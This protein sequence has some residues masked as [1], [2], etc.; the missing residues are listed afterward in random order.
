MMIKLFILGVLILFGNPAWGDVTAWVNKN[1]VVV[2]DM[3]QLHVEAKN[4][5]DAE[6]PDLSEITGFQILNRSVQN[7]TSIVGTSITRTLSW[8]Y[9]MIAPSSG[10]YLIPALKVGNEQSTPI[11]LKVTAYS[12]NQ[13]QKYVSLDME[14]FPKKVY[15]QQQI[16]VRLRISRTGVQLENETITPFELKGALVEELSQ[17]SHQTVKNG[18]KHKITEILY[19]V[20][21]E[22]SGTLVIPQV[23]YQGEIIQRGSSQNNFGNIFQKRGQRI[24]ST[25]TTQSVEVKALP[26]GFKNWW[27]PTD[28]LVIEEKWQPDP[29]VFRVGEPVTR[30]VAIFVNGVSGN[31]IPELKFDYPVTLKGYADQP[32]I[33][34]EK[35]EKGLKGMRLEKWALIPSQ[36]GKIELPGVSVSWWDIKSDSLQTAVISPKIFDI[37]P[38]LENLQEIPEDETPELQVNQAATAEVVQEKDTAIESFF[39]KILAFGFAFIW[40]ATML[41]WFIN[42]N[43]KAAAVTKNENKFI[44][45]RK[46]ALREATRNAEKAFRS[47]DPGIVQTALLKWGTAVWIDDPPQGLEQIGERLPELKN[48]INDLNLVLYGNN[49]TKESSM[50]KLFNDFNKVSLLDK[51]FNN[52]K[53]QPQLEPLYPE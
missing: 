46:T 22:K 23:R 13:R 10:D 47:G 39:W 2:G 27:L 21:P 44:Q 9:I 53:V 48:G 30:T 16:L 37:L 35:S 25:S 51:K 43:N 19:A 31:Q 24:F 7:Q 11:A 45:N 29:P 28:K 42:K 41:M 5:D 34:T 36:P 32:L 52:N 49:Q 18:K 14:V 3:F 26:T 40:C 50:E 8:T 33:E 4:V 1:P 38:V 15:P 17:K 20:I 12:Q 6:E